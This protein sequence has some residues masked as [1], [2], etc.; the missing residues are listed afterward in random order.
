MYRYMYMYLY[1]SA[2]QPYITITMIFL[3]QHNNPCSV[4]MTTANYCIKQLLSC[5]PYSVKHSNVIIVHW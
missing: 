5:R 2:K 4:A 3:T 1:Q